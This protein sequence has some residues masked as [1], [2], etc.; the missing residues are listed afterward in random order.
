M[1][2]KQG[3]SLEYREPVAKRAMRAAIKTAKRKKELMTLHQLKDELNC[4]YPEDH[5]E[6]RLNIPA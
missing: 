3:F 6:T 2:E 1:S 5:P 4:K